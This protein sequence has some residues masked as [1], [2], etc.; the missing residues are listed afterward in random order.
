MPNL[1][2]TK[3]KNRFSRGKIAFSIN[4]ARGKKKRKIFNLGFPPY[5]NI[6][7]KLI[8]DLNIEGKAIIKF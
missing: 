3:V 7:S 6:H 5:I 2:L 1:F 4:S 8:I